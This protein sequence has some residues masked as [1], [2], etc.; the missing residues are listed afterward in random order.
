MPRKE[1]FATDL[2]GDESG[3]CVIAKERTDPT[4]TSSHLA[5]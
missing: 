2:T 3:G 1:A 5:L 4:G